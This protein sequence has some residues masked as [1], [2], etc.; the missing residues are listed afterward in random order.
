MKRR[1][2]LYV[3]IPLAAAGL[4]AGPAAAAMHVCNQTSYLLYTAVGYESGLNMLTRGWSRIAPGDCATAIGEKLSQPAYFLYARSS[5]AHSG[6]SRAW[7]G[8]IR[9]C[10][11]DTDFSL[12]TPVGAANC[13]TDDAFLMPFASV[14]TRNAAEWTTTLT[15][16]PN[17]PTPDA[18]RQAGID[19]LLG[20]IGYKVDLGHQRGASARDMALAKFRARMKLPVNASTTDLF[21]ALETQALKAAAPAGYSICNDGDADIWAALGQRIGKTLV[22]RGWWKV[23]PGACAKAMTDALAIDKVYLLAEK[24][25][26]NHLVAGPT[27]FCVTDIQFEIFGNARCGARGLTEAGFASTNTNGLN[28]YAAHV[29]NDGLVPPAR[30]LSQAR[31]PK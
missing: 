11:K 9:L 20:D 28:G 30:Q 27:K 5:Q 29:S 22:S 15:E 14:T 26:N 8:P 17:L 6:P 13:G 23:A 19:R 16:F 4:V 7:G 18:A 1:A 31:T 21:D 2:A 10:A 25:G 3:A 24:H 12:Q